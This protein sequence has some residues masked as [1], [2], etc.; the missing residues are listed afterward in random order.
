MGGR[1]SH[2]QGQVRQWRRV[3]DAGAR[4]RPWGPCTCR[5][6]SAGPGGPAE[7]AGPLPPFWGGVGRKGSRGGHDPLEFM[8][9]KPGDGT[10][11][12]LGISA[13]GDKDGVPGG[14][15][16]SGLVGSS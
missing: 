15:S 11:L 7:A 10:D 3:G 13:A 14:Y 12:H 2:Q 4:R 8:G 1:E 16:C 6:S 5:P 9:W